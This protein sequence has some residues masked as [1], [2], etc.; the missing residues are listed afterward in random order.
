MSSHLAADVRRRFLGTHFFNPPRY[1]KLLETIPGP[2]TDPA[3]LKAVATG[4]SG[5][6]QCGLWRY[7][8]MQCLSMFCGTQG[9]ACNT[10][11][12][13]STVAI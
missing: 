12:A 6:D 1:L 10:D 8:C 7:G 11:A 5:V 4:G 9:Q 3:V 2:E 13:C